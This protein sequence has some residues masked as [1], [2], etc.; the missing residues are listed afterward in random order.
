MQLNEIPS[1]GETDM[2]LNRTWSPTLLLFISLNL[3][4]Q[5]AGQKSFDAV[6]SLAGNWHG[7]TSMGG[8]VQVSYKDTA[9]GSAVMAEIKSEMHGKSEDMISMF[10]MDGD[11]L[12]LTHYCAAGN[13]PRMQ[14][15]VSSDGKTISFDFL[16]ATNLASPDDGHMQR[17]VFTFTD[18][19]HHSEEWHFMN[20]G[21]EMVER[22]D[23]QR[24]S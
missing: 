13:Q 7:K 4:A 6:K 18:A 3:M 9:G 16:D 12:L 24:K 11:R 17:V 1:T 21:K 8:P 5:S 14:A 20:H 15:T 19:N 22:F 10:H 2:K 23:L